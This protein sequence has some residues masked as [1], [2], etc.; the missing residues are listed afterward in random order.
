MKRGII[1]LVLIVSMVDPILTS[2]QNTTSE[3]QSSNCPMQF[4]VSD[5]PKVF[6]NCIKSEYHEKFSMA[7]PNQDFQKTDVIGKKGLKDRRLVFWHQCN[8]EFILVYEH[9]GWGYHKHVIQ[10]NKTSEG[11]SVVRNLTAM[12]ASTLDDVKQILAEGKTRPLDHF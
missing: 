12:K 3:Q 5:I 11:Y 7:N 10:I 1:S 6:K 4:K 9:G 2:G 8:N